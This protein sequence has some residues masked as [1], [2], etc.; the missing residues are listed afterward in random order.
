MLLKLPG[1][2]PGLQSQEEGQRCTPACSRVCSQDQ[3]CRARFGD[4]SC[5]IY[6]PRRRWNHLFSPPPLSFLVRTPQHKQQHDATVRASSSIWWLVGTS[7]VDLSPCVSAV[8]PL[9]AIYMI[10]H[11]QATSK[12]KPQP[13]TAIIIK[14][15]TSLLFYSKHSSVSI[16]MVVG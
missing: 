5:T 6:H 16:F 15:A 13:Q 9:L 14:T 10:T 4:T 11:L 3:S 1:G 7:K 8:I 12:Y 2:A